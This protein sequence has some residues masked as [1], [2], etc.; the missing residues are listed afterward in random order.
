MLLPLSKGLWSVSLLDLLGSNV[1]STLMTLLFSVVLFRSIWIVW[2]VRVFL[3][4]QDAEL[5]LWSEKCHFVQKAVKYLGHVVSAEGICPDPAKTEVVVSYP[6]PT[7]A[8][9]VKQFMG[10]CMQ[11]LYRILVKDY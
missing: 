6:V 8:K 4:L 11:L 9:E 2:K 1:S 7:S 10:L 5:K 3:K